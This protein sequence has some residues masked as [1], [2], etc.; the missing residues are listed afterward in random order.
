MSLLASLLSPPVAQVLISRNN[1]HLEHNQAMRRKLETT[2]SQAVRSISGRLN[3]IEE[4]IS[5]TA[6][7]ATH[8]LTAQLQQMQDS[9]VCNVSQA[10]DQLAARLEGG[11]HDDL[12][13]RAPPATS[14][15]NTTADHS[16]SVINRSNPQTSAT[17]AV[18]ADSDVDPD[19]PRQLQKQLMER[20]EAA[21][22]L[23]RSQLQRTE[24]RLLLDVAA[25]NDRVQVRN[26]PETNVTQC[27]FD[28]GVWNIKKHVMCPTQ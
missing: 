20:V 22:M 6:S 1:Q 11:R 4:R 28:P 3:T 10:M 7:R 9:I 25:I 23:L 19:R 2:S 16:A 14:A 26:A 21:E 18:A 24:K 5:S 13:S 17:R 12:N 27:N 15:V 8:Q